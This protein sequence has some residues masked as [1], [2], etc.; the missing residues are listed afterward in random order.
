[1][2]TCLALTLIVLTSCRSVAGGVLE[3]ADA[4]LEDY[5]H[6]VGTT[7][8]APADAAPLAWAPGQFTVY[9]RASEG[10]VVLERV[11]IGRRRGDG[12]RVSLERLGRGAQLRVHL[13]L[14]RQPAGREE[15]AAL[16]VEAW[17]TRD[18][19]PEVNTVGAAPA[20]VLS[21]AAE[22]LLSPPRDG[23]EET[24]VVPAGRFEGCRGGTHP[25]VPI[26]GVVRQ[27]SGDAAR[28]LLEF[29]DDNAGALF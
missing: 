7:W 3:R 11:A 5:R 6:R 20:D 8:I 24:I 12:F 17:V 22:L 1:V 16:V 9:S 4:L 25:L 26:S 14:R 19:G 29:G 15:F 21:L 2:R 23:G 27:R 10:S 28:E 18:E 13:T